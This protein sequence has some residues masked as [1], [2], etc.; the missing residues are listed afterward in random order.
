V[1]GILKKLEGDDRRSIGRVE[2]LQE[3]IQTGSAAVKSRGK[4][5][6]AELKKQNY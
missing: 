2:V 1:A 6:P 4:K 5:L 3:M